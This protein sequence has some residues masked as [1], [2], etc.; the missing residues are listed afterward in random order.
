VRIVSGEGVCLIVKK[1]FVALLVA[2]LH[3]QTVISTFF[4]LRDCKASDLK[5]HN[6]TAP[7]KYAK[8]K[9]TSAR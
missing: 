2:Q 5:N 6:H 1:P 9:Q 4:Y 8:L 7:Y 3:N